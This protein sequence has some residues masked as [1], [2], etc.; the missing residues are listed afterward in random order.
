MATG[1]MTSKGQI[2]IPKSVR[3]DLDLKPGSRVQFV[4]TAD[5][6]YE[7]RRE[8]RPVKKLAGALRYSG[9]A[10]SLEEMDQAIASGAEDSQK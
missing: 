8:H 2:T 6:G 3:E 1:T 7:L 9:P 10:K 4:K 5:G